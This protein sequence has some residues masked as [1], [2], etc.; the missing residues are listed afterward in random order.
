MTAVSKAES[1]V[2]VFAVCVPSSHLAWSVVSLYKK[3]SMEV[4]RYLMEN[5]K[6]K[7]TFTMKYGLGI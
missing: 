2:T 6:Q 3:F 1:K 7:F 4:E 5:V